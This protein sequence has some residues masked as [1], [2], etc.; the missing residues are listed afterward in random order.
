MHITDKFYFGKYEQFK[1]F[2]VYQGNHFI[3]VELFKGYLLYLFKENFKP[4][5]TKDEL[6]N[7]FKLEFKDDNLIFAPV[8]GTNLNTDLIKHIESG[9]FS[10]INILMQRLSGKFS[11]E[12]F[13][14]ITC[15]EQSKKLE[16]IDGNP[17]Y[18]YWCIENRPD[19]FLEPDELNI[20]EHLP[21]FSFLGFE[22]K[23]ILENTFKFSPLIKTYK[24]RLPDEIRDF[25]LEK[26]NNS[27]YESYGNNSDDKYDGYGQCA[28]EQNPC[29]CSDPDPG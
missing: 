13:C 14:R 6:S 27:Q 10:N 26:F 11:L 21:I 24:N 17:K 2:Q 8:D 12:D 20:L 18:I 25:N 3:D 22:L 7:L 19:F 29:E 5:N 16:I 15:L 1:I 23:Y 9:A 4:N 28:C